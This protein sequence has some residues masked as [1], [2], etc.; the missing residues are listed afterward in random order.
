MLDNS[1][2]SSDYIKIELPYTIHTL[3]DAD[4]IP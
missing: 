3:V 2:S 4:N 1:I